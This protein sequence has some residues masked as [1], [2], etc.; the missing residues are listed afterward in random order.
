M[1]Y[2]NGDATSTLNALLLLNAMSPLC[3]ARRSA[4]IRH[5]QMCIQTHAHARSCRHAHTLKVEGTGGLGLEDGDS[6]ALSQQ[7][8]SMLTAVPCIPPA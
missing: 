2:L 5:W 4:F 3:R 7:G 6:K 1:R 8:Y